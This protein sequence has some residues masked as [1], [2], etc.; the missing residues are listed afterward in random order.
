M[1][2]IFKILFIIMTLISVA[3]TEDVNNLNQN[4]ADESKVEK[5]PDAILK[6]LDNK[7][8]SISDIVES[9][10]TLISFW[11]LACEPCKKEM[12]YLDE[13]NMKYADSGFQ[14]I[15]IN[16]DGSRALS[17][18]EPFVD[19]KKYSFKVLSD[20]RSKYQRKLK[21]ASCPF[22]VIV[23]HNGNIISRHVGFNSGDEKKL[24]KEILQLINNAQADTL[25]LN[26]RPKVKDSVNKPPEDEE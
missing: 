4:I 15:S 11:F 16:T 5:L 21:G 20:P 23:D 2:M 26:T 24:E 3:I 1:T 6:D 14:V 8:V 10:P 13:F 22:T 19:S 7:K 18:V 17:S 12:K 25:Y 9:R